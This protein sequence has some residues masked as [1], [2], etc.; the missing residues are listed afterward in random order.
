MLA[1]RRVIL[2][3]IAITVLV[4]GGLNAY[5]YVRASHQAHCARLQREYHASLIANRRP[6][7]ESPNESYDNILANS[8]A[9]LEEHSDEDRKAGQGLRDECP[10]LLGGPRI[11]EMSALGR[12]RNGG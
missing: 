7:N 1:T 4:L 5:H 2:I 11:R 8:V 9:W 3:P 12:K 10:E 6:A